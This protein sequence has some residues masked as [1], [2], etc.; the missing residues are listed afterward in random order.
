VIYTHSFHDVQRDHR[1]T[2][3][4][5]VEAVRQV[6]RVYCFQS[7]SATVDF[8]PTRFVTIDEQLERKLLAVGAFGSQAE[9]HSYVERGLVESTACYWSRFGDGR[10]A[11][12][13]EVMR[14]AAMTAG[15]PGAVQD[16]TAI[17]RGTRCF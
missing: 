10:Y 4:A 2:H 1:G 3:R 15:L 14:E 12:A 13:L 11:E 16:S 9:V 7:P 17:R 8:R 5:A 6:E